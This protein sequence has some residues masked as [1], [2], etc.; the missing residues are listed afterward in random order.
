V[1]LVNVPG[2]MYFGNIDESCSVNCTRTQLQRLDIQL[3]AQRDVSTV[4]KDW[5]VKAVVVD[6]N[7]SPGFIYSILIASNETA[8]LIQR[9]S[10]LGCDYQREVLWSVT[11][12]THLPW[13]L[14]LD[15]VPTAIVDTSSLNLINNQT[16]Y[17]TIGTQNPA[18]N[19]IGARTLY[20]VVNDGFLKGS[21][22]A[23]YR[24]VLGDS[25]A[26]LIVADDFFKTGLIKTGLAVD[27]IGN[28]LYWGTSRTET[29]IKAG[30]HIYRSPLN[31]NFSTAETSIVY[32]L[33]GSKVLGLAL[34]AINLQFTE[35]S[36]SSGWG[37]YIYFSIAGGSILIGILAIM[38]LLDLWRMSRDCKTARSVQSDVDGGQVEEPYHSINQPEGHN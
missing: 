12:T 37:W 31:G 28:Y 38:A 7:T 33:S 4:N 15:S 14:A 10:L 1:D 27:V 29:L 24:L 6:T 11:N 32:T 36:S 35:P 16:Y 18:P 34:D 25:K 8:G 17:S 20:F 21:F 5:Q 13:A 30:C 19:S 3:H 26:V 9:C 22:S 2:W 23:I